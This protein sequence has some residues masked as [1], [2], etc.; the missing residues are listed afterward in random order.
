MSEFDYTDGEWFDHDAP[1][2]TER[3]HNYPSHTCEGVVTT[4]VSRSG[5]STSHKCEG[6]QEDLAGRLAAIDERYP[7]SSVAPSWFDPTY[8]GERW[9]SDY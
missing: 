9:D 1:A 8:A 5:L 6:C 2:P 7:D 4:V 3:C